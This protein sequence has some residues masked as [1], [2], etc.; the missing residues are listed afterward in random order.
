L[1]ARSASESAAAVTRC[2]N[3]PD[4]N[5]SRAAI[6]ALGALGDE[7]Q[8]A[9]LIAMLKAGKDAGSIDKA[10]GSICGRAKEKAAADV[11]AGMRGA[12]SDAQVVLYN[13]L[14]RCGGQKA[15]DAVLA[16]TK[17]SDA[18]AADGAIRVLCN[19]PD[20]AALDPLLALAGST[21]N[22]THQILAVRGVVRL[23][24]LRETPG[25]VR[26]QALSKAMDLAKKTS[27]KRQVLGALRDVQTIQALRLV[28]QYVAVKGLTEE[29]GSAA[30]RIADRVWNR[31]KDLARK[32]ML[33]VV[34]NVRSKRTKNDA[35]KVLAKIG[36]APK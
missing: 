30:V 24:R 13:A 5:V 12:K 18:K 11:I 33:A 8:V 35:R 19:W 17:S 32:T 22:E 20:R 4:A 9:P 6:E 23:A 1:A 36:P 25:N 26:W 28:S 7:K 27:E 31:D 34:E 21:E 16:G 10:L 15:L 2:A 29:A 3:D 14:G